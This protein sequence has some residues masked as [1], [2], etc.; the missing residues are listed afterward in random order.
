MLIWVSSTEFIRRR[1]SH[2]SGSIEANER[3]YFV[4]ATI[5]PAEPPFL[6]PVAVTSHLRP[7]NIIVSSHGEF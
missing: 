3:A 4:T 5:S 6:N 1:L 2:R 7:T